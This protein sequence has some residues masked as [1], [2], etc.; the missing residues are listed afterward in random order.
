LHYFVPYVLAD[1]PQKGN[2]S[3]Y[4][5]VLTLRRLTWIAAIPDLTRFAWTALKAQCCS[6]LRKIRKTSP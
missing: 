1:F 6:P 5:Y 4:V 2:T 3:L